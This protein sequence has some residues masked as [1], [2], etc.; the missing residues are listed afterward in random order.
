M[1]L[2]ETI[3]SSRTEPQLCETN[4][5]EF[6]PSV[7]RMDRGE[8]LGSVFTSHKNYRIRSA[9]MVLEITCGIIHLAVHNE[10]IIHMFRVNI[11]NVC[12]PL[13]THGVDWS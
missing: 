1:K 5:S 4:L 10:L 13:R 9:R 2:V 3:V 6:C 7:G 12:L 11:H 8:V